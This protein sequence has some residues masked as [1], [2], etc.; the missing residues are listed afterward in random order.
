MKEILLVTDTWTPQVNGVVTTWK[1]IINYCKNNN[2]NF[3]VIHPYLFKNISW[4]F[5]KEIKLPLVTF[6]K[7]E[8]LIE[9]IN[10]EHIHIATEG[11]LGWHTRK[12][13]NKRK[14]NFT[15]SYHTK[16]PEF[17]KSLYGIPE[18]ITYPIMKKFHSS[19]IATL[20]NTPTMKKELESKGFNNL[21]GWTRGV[22]RGLFKPNFDKKLRDIIDPGGEK[23]I[24]LY[25]GRVSKEKNIKSFCKIS[26]EREDYK[27]VIVGDGPI[28]KQLEKDYP[29][30]IFTGFKHGN[31]LVRYYS[32]ADCCVFPSLNDTFGNTILES[33]ACGTPVAAFPINGPID[34][35]NQGVSGY[36]DSNLSYA[37]EETL[38][39]SREYTLKT[40]EKYDWD[41]CIKILLAT[42]DQTE[43]YKK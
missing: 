25:V 24:I 32:V 37:I 30:I 23:K 29:K 18:K 40:I 2:I 43:S 20:V 31:E 15:T 7:I 27:L 12:Y 36:F 26:K 19:S 11:I 1:N 8:N 17:L 35:I 41:Q 38:K 9:E 16:F 39:C 22:D 21:I 4:P 14:I 5:Y 28:K 6:K 10:P 3:S 42:L 13:C 34:I 33:I